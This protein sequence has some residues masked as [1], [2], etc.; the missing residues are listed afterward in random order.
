MNPT[1]VIEHVIII[2]EEDDLWDPQYKNQALV[3]GPNLSD[4]DDYSSSTI[5]TNFGVIERYT[6]ILFPA[7][8]IQYSIHPNLIAKTY[9]MV[10]SDA[11][12]E[13][14]P[15]EKFLSE[16]KILES[17]K[18]TCKFLVPSKHKNDATLELYNYPFTLLPHVDKCINP[19]MGAS[20]HNPVSCVKTE[21]SMYYQC[22]RYEADS[23]IILGHADSVPVKL[24][25]KINGNNYSFNDLTFTSYKEIMSY[26]IK[27]NIEFDFTYIPIEDDDKSFYQGALKRMAVSYDRQ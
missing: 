11:I 16:Y 24:N 12:P 27:E 14:H 13:I 23:E 9:K 6:V 25:R 4:E 22:D 8:N 20:P 26:F 5:V 3:F 17:D 15:I 7:S 10:V 1:F 21:S 19:E 18:P 2:Q